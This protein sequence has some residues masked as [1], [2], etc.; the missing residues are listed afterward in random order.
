MVTAAFNVNGSVFLNSKKRM[1]LVKFQ[2]YM[3]AY[4]SISELKR[5]SAQFGGICFSTVVLPV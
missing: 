2:F 3:L 4:I 5:L 1:H